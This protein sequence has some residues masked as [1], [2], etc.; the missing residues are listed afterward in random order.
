MTGSP[1]TKWQLPLSTSIVLMF[2]A[3]GLLWLLLTFGTGGRSGLPVQF[4]VP[5][6]Y[7]GA[8]KLVEDEIHG[9]LPTASH[10]RLIYTVPAD[11]I[12]LIKSSPALTAWHQESAIRQDEREIP[13]GGANS[14]AI[15]FFTLFSGHH[16]NSSAL[17]HWFLIG[18]RQEWLEACDNPGRL[19]VNGTGLKFDLEGLSP[20]SK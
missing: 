19:Q 10:G 17:E 16:N 14:T 4:V 11:G 9:I 18:T 6:D 15:A 8:F 7:H 20:D 12:L 1:K 3:A 13:N 5:N 2:I